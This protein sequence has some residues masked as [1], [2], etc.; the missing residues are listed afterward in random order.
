MLIAVAA[1]LGLA[2]LSTL[3]ESNDVPDRLHAR[4]SREL[5]GT[6]RPP[7]AGEREA[8]CR[9]QTFGGV[10]SNY[11]VTRSAYSF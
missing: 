7:G 1:R 9:R 8:T 2:H 5:A 10:R 4:A 3:L 6:Y 11:L